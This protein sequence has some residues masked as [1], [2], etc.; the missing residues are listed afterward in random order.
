MPKSKNAV[1]QKERRALKVLAARAS[2]D[3]RAWLDELH[4]SLDTL[5]ENEIKRFFGSDHGMRSKKPDI[6][7]HTVR[8]GRAGGCFL[9]VEDL[10]EGNSEKLTELLESRRLEKI[11]DQICVHEGEE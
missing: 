4:S 8:N 7:L 1:S 2:N 5:I 3:C 9:G 11:V 10:Q 6:L